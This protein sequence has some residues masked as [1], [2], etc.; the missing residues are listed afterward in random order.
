MIHQ[1]KVV[2]QEKIKNRE[3]E[4]ERERENKKLQKITC[5]EKQ[6]IYIHIK[7]YSNKHQIIQVMLCNRIILYSYILS[8]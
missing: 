3:R 2:L 6:Y 5:A 1:S 8:L 7:R 4:R